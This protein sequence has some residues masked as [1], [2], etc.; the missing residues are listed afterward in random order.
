ML[1]IEGALRNEL[2]N[3]LEDTTCGDDADILGWIFESLDDKAIEALI[4]KCER[5]DAENLQ[6]AADHLSDVKK[7]R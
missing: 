6:E 3:K 1:V 2:Y 4:A 5:E 7:D